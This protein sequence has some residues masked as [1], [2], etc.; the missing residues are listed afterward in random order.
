[1]ARVDRR[2]TYVMHKTCAPEGGENHSLMKEWAFAYMM[3]AAHIS[4]TDPRNY[5][6]IEQMRDKLLGCRTE[7][8]GLDYHCFR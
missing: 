2:K 4:L 7:T 5:A 8:L 6:F 3:A 1:M